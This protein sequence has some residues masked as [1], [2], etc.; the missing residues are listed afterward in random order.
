[1]AEDASHG[2]LESSGGDGLEGCSG[3]ARVGPGASTGVLPVGSDVRVLWTTALS[4]QATD[5]VTGPLPPPAAAPPAA[6][7][8]LGNPRSVT[9]VTT[10]SGLAFDLDTGGPR[11]RP[12]PLPP[13][14]PLSS[15]T[16]KEFRMAGLGP[17]RACLD[18]ST[19]PAVISEALEQVLTIG[20]SDMIG[21]RRCGT[22][23]V[24]MATS[25]VLSNER[26]VAMATG[27]RRR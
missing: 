11:P 8:S 24:A 4:R 19:D 18:V 7:H 3:A 25:R 2:G 21:P 16:L 10:A 13:P 26:G 23:K 17:T 12:F 27:P 14:G 20:R 22:I 9:F 15:T 6:G 1:M 5:G